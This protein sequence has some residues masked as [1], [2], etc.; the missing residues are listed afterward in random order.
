MSHPFNIFF[1]LTITVFYSFSIQATTNQHQQRTVDTLRTLLA[2]PENQ[3]DFT[4]AKLAI[5]QLIDPSI[6]IQKIN[7]ELNRIV[8][9][10]LQLAGPNA[11]NDHK[12]AALRTYI[13]KAGPWNNNKPFAYDMKDP[14]GTHL[15]SK[16]LVNYMKTRKGNCISMPFLF[17]ALAD[18]MGLPVTA[19]TAP[20][21]VFVKY[22]TDAGKWINLET[23]SGAHPSRDVWIQKQMP[24]TDEA[25]KNGMFLKTMS[26][27]ETLVTM[28]QVLVEHAM[29]ER[30]YGLVL[31]LTDMLMPHNKSSAALLLSRGSAAYRILEHE[32]YKPY[33]HPQ[34]IPPHKKDMWQQL[35]GINKQAFDRAE[36][37]GWRPPEYFK[38]QKQKAVSP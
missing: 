18:K 22:K 24:F 9:E 4:K 37:L 19:S 12:I 34:M 27:K 17:I 26:R 21:H 6:D 7:A 38:A 31:A 10:V 30:R 16:L 15:P 2:T 8:L 25:K 14:L 1:V 36:A 29:H 5:D 13:Y 20:L 28:A 3:I 35:E 23:T 32:I 11:S 33:P